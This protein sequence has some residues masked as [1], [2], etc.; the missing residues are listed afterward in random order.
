MKRIVLA[1]LIAIALPLIAQAPQQQP[2]AVPDAQR[3]VAIL[4]GEVITAE[5][6]DH[7]YDHMGA[8]MRG[9][10]YEQFL[11]TRGA[12]GAR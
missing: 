5:K 4:N 8:Q 1:P 7:L 3:P 2:T 6:L 11:T 10:S 12:K 9:E